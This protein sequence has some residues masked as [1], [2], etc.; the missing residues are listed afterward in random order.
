MS[1]QPR[2]YPRLKTWAWYVPDDPPHD[3]P[4]LISTT[5]WSEPTRAT[6]RLLVAQPRGVIGILVAMVISAPIGALT[7]L[8]IGQAT[9]HAFTETSWWTLGFPVLAVMVILYVQYLSEASADAFTDMSQTRTTHTLRLGLLDRL[10]ASP[11]ALN[12]GRLLNTVDEDSDFVGKLK[13]ILN[14]PIMMVG[15]L[16]GGIIVIAPISW[17]VAIA[18]PVG[19][20]CT[21]LVSG[22]TAAPLSRAAAKRRSTQAASL[23]IATDVA[24]GNRVVKGLGAGPVARERFGA[25]AATALDAMLAEVRLM[26][27][28]QFARQLVPTSFAIGI[29]VWAGWQTFE[30]AINPGGMMTITMLVPPAM[31]ALGHSLGMLTEVWSRGKASAVRVGAL[32]GEL[33]EG[34]ELPD[35]DPGEVTG[36]VVWNPQTPAARAQVAAWTRHLQ[37]HRGALCPPHR[38]SVL[39]GTLEDNIDPEGTATDVEGALEAA[40]CSDI[41]R[42]LGGFGSHGELPA[43]PI[44]EAGLN[45]SGGQR[46]RVALARALAANPDI[47]VLDEPTTGLDSLTLAAVAER[48]KEFRAGRTTVVITSAATW[49]A[50]ADKVVTL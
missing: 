27:V 14:F 11:A 37:R 4:S 47:L 2:L 23:A 25:S 32:L 34:E 43:A 5:P 39:E 13:Q 20:I 29:L 38:V 12:P 26:A 24:Q 42:R 8:L 18:M 9:E 30:G 1:S 15:Y 28:L 19:A 22:A 21:A 46:Q 50:N 16:T 48:T 44:G 40:A 6:R 36:L 10:L 7:S 41:V 33:G 31:T 49:A 45:L 35:A 17:Q 3:D